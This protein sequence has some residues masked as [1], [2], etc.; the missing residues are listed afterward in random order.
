MWVLYDYFCSIE[1]FYTLRV[2]RIF[3]SAPVRRDTK[4]LG[5]AISINSE[6]L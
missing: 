6:T 3:N 1:T 5:S 2:L 4:L